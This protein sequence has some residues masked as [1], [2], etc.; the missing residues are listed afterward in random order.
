[1]ESIM[2]AIWKRRTGWMA[3]IA[4]AASM[5]ATAAHAQ[6]GAR[7]NMSP[8]LTNH[9]LVQL[10]QNCPGGRFYCRSWGWCWRNVW[11]G[12]RPFMCCRQ[13]VCY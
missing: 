12:G 4:V 11:P 10:V 3:G 2:T 9:S 7:A 13:Y 6:V 8:A 5:L 1:M